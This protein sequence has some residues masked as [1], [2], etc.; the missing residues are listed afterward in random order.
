M[1]G[2]LPEFRQSR[3]TRFRFRYSE[4]HR[5]ADACPHEAITLTDEGAR[6]DEDGC[7]H[8]GLCA[9]AC[10]T[11]AWESPGFPRLEILRR[12]ASEPRWSFA[13]A[14]SGIAADTVVDCLGVIDASTLAYLSRRAVRVELRGTGHCDGCVH[15]ARGPAQ[16]EARLAAVEALQAAAGEDWPAISIREEPSAR[17]G[18]PGVFAPERRQLL[19]KLLDAATATPRAPEETAPAAPDKAIRAARTFVTDRRQLLQRVADGRPAVSF[20]VPRHPAID[21]LTLGKTP[22]C[23]ACEA[24]FRACP[25]GAI[26][27]RETESAWSL[28][29]RQHA[30]VGCEVCLEVCQPRVLQAQPEVELAP[31]QPETTIHA[32]RKQRCQRCDRAFVSSRPE[33]SCP[34]CADDETAFDAL[35]G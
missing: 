30:C 31:A 7:R 16:V 32:L 22:G 18:K 29:F 4:C 11:G 28:V 33:Q 9:S 2:T 24:C 13:C 23:T 15:G 6:L 14:P 12:A 8:C 26:Q 20:K 25:A 10:R 3:C 21:A 5:C 1:I 27:V 19:R 17:A 34:V 35:F